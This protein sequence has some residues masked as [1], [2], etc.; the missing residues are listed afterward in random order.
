[1]APVAPCFCHSRLK[2]SGASNTA[3]IADFARK[4]RTRAVKSTGS[5][6]N[7][8]ICYIQPMRRFAWKNLRL[9]LDGSEESFPSAI[10]FPGNPTS[11]RLKCLPTI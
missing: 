2:R 6:L 10:A 1:M 3:S 4:S 7:F 9:S 11:S 5:R 8:L